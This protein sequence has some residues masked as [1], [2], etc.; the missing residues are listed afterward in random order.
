MGRLYES[1]AF[2]QHLES[3]PESKQSNISK[4][5]FYI[6][7]PS[8]LDASPDG[9]IEGSDNLKIIEIK[10]PYSIRD[11]EIEEAC[12]TSDFYCTLNNGLLH[13]N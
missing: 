3:Q 10:C 8:F 7:E 4:A 9:V 12:A 11:F 6:G 5:A 1:D 13:L 2:C